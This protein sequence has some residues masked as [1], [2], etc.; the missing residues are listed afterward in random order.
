MSGVS[1][2]LMLVAAAAVAGGLVFGLVYGPKDALVTAG[3]MLAFGAPAVVGAHLLAARRRS[4]GGLSR[5]FAAGIGLS[6]GVVTLGVGAI[7]LLM[8]VS[9][10]D[11]LTMIVLLVFAGGLTAYAASVLAAAVMRDIDAVGAGVTAVG[12]GRRELK[13]VT[14]ADD[15]LAGLAAAAERMATRLA[16]TEAEREAADS[17]RRDLIAAVSHDLRT[18]LTSLRLLAEAIEDGLVD[19]DTAA[20]YR[21]QMS[22]HITSLAHLVD[23][24]FELSRLEAGEIRWSMQRVA[25]D[26]LVEETVEAM[27]PQAEDRSVAVHAAVNGS[28]GAAHADPEQVQR[29]LFNL[30]Q[31]AIR[32]TPADGSVTVAAESNGVSVELEVADTGEGLVPQ[33]RERAFEPFYRGGADS[34][35]SGDG[36]G[37]GLAIC[38]AIVEAHGGR[39]WFAESVTGTRVRFTLPLAA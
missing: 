14:A 37:L 31:N 11:A 10:H 28:V 17:A 26:E 23:D 36:T 25:L 20:R 29:V 7:A 12:E 1:R 8:F 35:R 18:P 16:A 3:L 32:H 5:Q 39:I 24:L 30:I 34:A 33:D 19:Q 21:R 9:P 27:R 4:L 13:I 2:G 15:E 22:T 38:R 6:V